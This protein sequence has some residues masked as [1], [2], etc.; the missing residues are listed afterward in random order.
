MKYGTGRLW[1][2]IRKTGG[3]TKQVENNPTAKI[4]QRIPTVFEEFP[5]FFTFNSSDSVPFSKRL[6]YA[7]LPDG[8]LNISF[9][10]SAPDQD[11]RE[12]TRGKERYA[13]IR[14]CRYHHPRIR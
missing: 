12:Q 7:T 3:Y 4:Q 9:P 14:T 10:F 8:H 11:S 13:R 5:E 2:M 1:K 6:F